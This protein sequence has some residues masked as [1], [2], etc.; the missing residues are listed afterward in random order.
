MLY[1]IL[2][3]GKNL[4]NTFS[5]VLNQS[6]DYFCP[7]CGSIVIP[8]PIA[9]SNTAYFLHQHVFKSCD[10]TF[11]EQLFLYFTKAFPADVVLHLPSFTHKIEEYS[12]P[13]PALPHKVFNFPSYMHKFDSMLMYFTKESFSQIYYPDEKIKVYKAT[14]G[15]ESF[16]VIFNFFE[17]PFNFYELDDLLYYSSTV[18]ELKFV[19][20]ITE[21]NFQSDL[22]IKTLFSNMHI[23]YIRNEILMKQIKQVERDKLHEY[24][25]WV[26]QQSDLLIQLQE[27]GIIRNR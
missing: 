9:E 1:I 27:L 4:L 12:I 22:N 2:D 23:M 6:D 19:E 21:R 24:E 18:L 20:S 26:Q 11:K 10:P 15:Q 14:S 3:K 17:L 5:L 13:Y 16:I 7:F 8:A 25:N